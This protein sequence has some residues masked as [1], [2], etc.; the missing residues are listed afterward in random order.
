MVSRDREIAKTVVYGI[1]TI[2]SLLRGIRDE[3]ATENAELRR[4]IRESRQET[5]DL[6]EQLARQGMTS[7]PKPSRKGFEFGCEI[8]SCSLPAGH[9]GNHRGSLRT[10]I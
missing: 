7:R 5:R 2:I 6:W 9:A 10:E 3:I 1:R 4:E 8:E